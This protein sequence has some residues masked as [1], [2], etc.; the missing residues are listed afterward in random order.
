MLRHKG[1]VSSLGAKW[2]MDFLAMSHGCRGMASH[3]SLPVWLSLFLF[4]WLFSLFFI[5]NLA[6]NDFLESFCAVL[7]LD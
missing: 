7:L 4:V 5:H 3:V 1:P 2:R 6:H